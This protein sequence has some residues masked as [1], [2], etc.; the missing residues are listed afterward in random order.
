MDLC[1]WVE[2]LKNDLIDIMHLIISRI[3][4]DIIQEVLVILRS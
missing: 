2:L 4:N 1:I 3:E